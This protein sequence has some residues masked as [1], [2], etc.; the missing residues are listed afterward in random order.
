MERIEMQNV[1]LRDCWW[2]GVAR[3]EV[4]TVEY[5]SPL[6]KGPP[7]TAEDDLPGGS[8]EVYQQSPCKEQE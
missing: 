1:L 2:K 6:L 3:E 7:E 8:G 5:D 4:R